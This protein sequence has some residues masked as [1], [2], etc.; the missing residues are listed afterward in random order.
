MVHVMTNRTNADVVYHALNKV[1]Q[2]YDE[3]HAM[4]KKVRDL[5]EAAAN[6]AKVDWDGVG[7]E[8]N[9]LQAFQPEK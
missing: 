8:I 7:T 2:E 4:L 6:G 9:R 5:A 3:M 1:R